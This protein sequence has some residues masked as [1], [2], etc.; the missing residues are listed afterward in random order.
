MARGKGVKQ[1]KQS[2]LPLNHSGLCKVINC[3]TGKA[4]ETTVN[5]SEQMIECEGV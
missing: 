5:Y 3:S 2:Y 4:K 1:S